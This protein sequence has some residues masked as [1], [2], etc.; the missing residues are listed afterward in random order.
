MT[1][2]G[3]GQLGV[4]TSWCHRIE[5]ASHL[6]LEES[7]RV[8]SAPKFNGNWDPLRERIPVDLPELKL[9]IH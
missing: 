8:I 4:Q 1:P 2:D 3:P 5:E 6:Y 7:T 9:W